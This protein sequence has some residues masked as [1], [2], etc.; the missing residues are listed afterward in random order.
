[1]NEKMIHIPEVHL[2]SSSLQAIFVQNLNRAK[3]SDSFE[4]REKS[5]EGISFGDLPEWRKALGVYY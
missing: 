5:F 3:E 4:I 1:M 2:H